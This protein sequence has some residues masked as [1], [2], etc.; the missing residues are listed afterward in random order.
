M[1][2]HLGLIRTF[3]SYDYTDARNAITDAPLSRRSKQQVKY[4]LD[5]QMYDFDWGIT[6]QYLGSRYDTDYSSWPYRTVKMGGGK[7][8]GSCGFVSRHLTA[9]SSW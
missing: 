4:Q 7:L 8:M 2:S 3:L 9:D 6:Y 5:W 1:I